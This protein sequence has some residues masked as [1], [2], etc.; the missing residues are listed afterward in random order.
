MDNHSNS[1]GVRPMSV[2]VR[3]R[4]SGKVSVRVRPP[5][6]GRDD[7][8][9]PHTNQHLQYDWGAVYRRLNT[10][11]PLSDEG[12]ESDALIQ[13][14]AGGG[15][16][17]VQAPVKF[18]LVIN[19]KAA[20][21]LGLDVPVHLQQRADEVIEGG[22]SSL[23]FSAVRRAAWPIAARAQQLP[24]IGFLRILGGLCRRVASLA[25]RLCSRRLHGLPHR[26]H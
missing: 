8:T 1:S 11:E 24:V 20:K 16:L 2:C 17:L 3:F 6:R 4:T 5:Y 26:S 23:R 10:G 21:A 18:E 22:A 13:S 15:E 19:L 12:D 25:G 7:R 14:G 9:W